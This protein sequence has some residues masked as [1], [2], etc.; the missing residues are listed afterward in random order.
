MNKLW[1]W[2]D[3]VFAADLDTRRSHTGYVLK[4]NGGSVSWIPLASSYYDW[5]VD[6]IDDLFRV[7]QKVKTQQVVKIC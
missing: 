4:L 5:V 7:T 2:V 1:D 6:Q 3:P